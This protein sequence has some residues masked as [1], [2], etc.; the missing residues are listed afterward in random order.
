[1]N[2]YVLILFL[3][4]PILLIIVGAVLKS[5]LESTKFKIVMLILAVIIIISGIMWRLLHGGF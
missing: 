3:L 2:D 4:L 5:R 1:M